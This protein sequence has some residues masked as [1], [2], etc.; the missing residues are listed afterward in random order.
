MQLPMDFIDLEKAPASDIKTKG[1]PGLMRKVRAN[2]AVVVTN[3]NHPEAVVVDAEQYR[4]L[5]AEASAASAA[6]GRAQSLK[7]L[8]TKFDEHLAS[9]KDANGLARALSRPARRGKKITLGKPL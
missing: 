1:W 5:V 8:Q 6:I 2:G 4:R 9:L 7:A 3:H